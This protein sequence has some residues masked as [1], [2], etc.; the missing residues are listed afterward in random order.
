M[1]DGNQYSKHELGTMFGVSKST[2]DRIGRPVPV[3]LKVAAKTRKPKRNRT[4]PRGGK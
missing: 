2:I 4:R 3:K 1:W